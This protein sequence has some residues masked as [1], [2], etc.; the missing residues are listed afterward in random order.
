MGASKFLLAIFGVLTLLILGDDV[1]TY[2]CL[3]VPSPHHNV[4][5]MN[6]VSAWMFGLLGIIPALALQGAVK[7]VG[8][9][10]LYRLA[11]R[12]PHTYKLIA[13]GM[14]IALIP[15]LFANVNNWRILYVITG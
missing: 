6:P 15:S 2:L 1:S 10:V 8:M 4:S 13:W 14:G 9:V 11:M 3:T 12:K 5:E 7:G